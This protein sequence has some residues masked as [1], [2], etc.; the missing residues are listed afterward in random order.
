MNEITY[1]AITNARPIPTK[2]KRGQRLEP[3]SCTPVVTDAKRSPGVVEP[4]KSMF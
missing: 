1:P 3:V 4:R 2:E